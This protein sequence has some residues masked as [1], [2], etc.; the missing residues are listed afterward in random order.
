MPA[1]GEGELWR[2]SFA[3]RFIKLT[4]LGYAL[5]VVSVGVV[6]WFATK[7]ILKEMQVEAKRAHLDT[8]AQV[9]A[10]V[11]GN[12]INEGQY[13]AQLPA[14]QAFINGGLDAEADVR[15]D[16][17][18][19]SQA[20]NIRLIDL[21]GRELLD[22]PVV[23]TPS[24]YL[25]VE[26]Q[27]GLADMVDGRSSPTPI[28]N[29]R[30]GDGTHKA[31]FLINL[32][33]Q[34]ESGFAGLMSFEVNSNFA[35][36]LSLE[37][38]STQTSMLTEFQLSYWNDW[39][40]E[41]REFV[42]VPVPGTNFFLAS[43]PDIS[44]KASN[45]AALVKVALGGA[46]V[47]LLIPFVALGVSGFQAIVKP[48]RQLERS[49]SELLEKTERLA[50]LAEVAEMASESIIVTDQEGRATWVNRA[51]SETT[52]Y[53]PSEIIGKKPGALLQGADT[54]EEAIRSI[55][56][57]L[58]K[59]KSIQCEMLNYTKSGEPHWIN[60]SI[61]PI[62]NSIDGGVRFASI[63]ADITEAKNARAELEREK[64]KTEHQARHDSLT[65]LP[66]RRAIDEALER[67]VRYNSHARTLVRIDLDHFKNVNDTLG[68]AAGDFV[69]K[70]VADIIW[71]QVRKGDL[72]ARTGGDEF[73]V[74]M[75]EGTTEEEALHFTERLRRMIR[76]E[77]RF[78][79]KTCRI[80]ASFGV[81]SSKAGLVENAELLKSADSALYFA[82]DEGRNKTVLYTPE[83]HQ[84]VLERRKISGELESAILEKKFIAYFQPQFDAQTETLVGVEALA[85]WNHPS[86]GILA[87]PEFMETAEKLKLVSD[88]DQQIFEYGLDRI[89]D[90]DA[91]G[92]GV[93]K[94]AFNL[95]AN[96]LMNTALSKVVAE[97]RVNST[98]IALEILESVLIEDQGKDFMERVKALKA[99]GFQIEVDDFGSGHAS[100]VSLQRLQPDVMK[101]DRELVM[102]VVDSHT[103]RSLVKSI[104]GMGHALGIEVIAEGVETAQHAAIMR[105]LGCNALQGYYFARPMPF[106]ALC[107]ILQSQPHGKPPEQVSRSAQT[108]G[109]NT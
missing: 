31:I 66:N 40:A 105:D 23:Q 68:H 21:Q 59:R 12:F 48:H 101:I 18:R 77:M 39:N 73:V 55:S 58:K 87:P 46:F 56:F 13:I 91:I 38:G 30:P 60:L 76:E 42:V 74:L 107:D 103:A 28:V 17:S 93:P 10:Q 49:R 11:L 37:K 16:L 24:R 6:I 100:V 70:R 22:P 83:L 29:Y 4:V 33:I 35:D 5:A 62:P 95:S 102:P 80:G 61:S 64:D 84:N 98:S 82:K 20:Q 43:Q 69:L 9:I 81:C 54:D 2:N 34:T 41:G 78:E 86:R 44:T 26:A 27:N 97:K 7:P 47:A 96:Q 14:V 79:G 51:F 85:R 1:A 75:Q 90:L 67:V 65:G 94:I 15:R 63:S 45:G 92:L 32:P 8:K 108:F 99:E 25:A 19:F 89:R 109:R 50:E 57:A 104:I 52:G 3:S 72:P 71:S 53:H 88:I 106:E 36:V